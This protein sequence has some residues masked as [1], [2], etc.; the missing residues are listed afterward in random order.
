MKEIHQLSLEYGFKIIEDAAHAIGSRYLETPTGSCKYSDITVFSFHPVKI[1]TSGE[2]G[3]LHTNDEEIFEE[4]S[5]LRSH[6]I[7]KKASELKNNLEG[8]WWYE[9][10]KLGFNY[11]MTDIQA[12]L[13]IRQL[14]RLDEYVE[15]RNFLAKRYANE[16]QKVPVILPLFESA[17][18]SSYHLYPIRLK[19]NAS[20]LNRRDV[21]DLLHARGIGVQVH[22]IPI[23]IQPYYR[24]M[25]FK[26]DYFPNAMTYYSDGISLPLFPS[27]SLYQQDKVVNTLKEILL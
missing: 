9:Q 20:D 25:G 15:R 11:R 21:F 2:G 27:M 24:D 12:A 16:L 10:H 18:L 19:L 23:H 26:E 17:S 7:T 14:L 22:Y 1:I 13:G 8:S 3:T 6:G 5:S 4:A